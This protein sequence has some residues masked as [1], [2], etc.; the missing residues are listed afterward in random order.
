[1]K[2]DTLEQWTTYLSGL[3]D[4]RLGVESITANSLQFVQILKE[5]GKEPGEIGAILKAF[6]VELDKRGMPLSDRGPRQMVS[7]YRLINDYP[8]GK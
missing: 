2:P 5:E 3:T 8:D 7:Y 1:M 4:E 6:A